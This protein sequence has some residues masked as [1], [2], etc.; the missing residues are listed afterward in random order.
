MK[1]IF[2][3][4]MLS[5]ST[6]AFSQEILLQQ[7]VKADTLKPTHGANLKHFFQGYIGLG[8]PI[9]TN[10]N[11]P[12]T[13]FGTSTA[14]DFGIRYKRK[15]AEHFAIGMD[16]GA[17]L[18]AYKI[19]QDNGKSVPDTVINNKEK[20]QINSL[21]SSVYTRINVGRRGNHIGN[22][23][24]LGIYGGWNCIKKHKSINDNAEGEKVKVITSQLKYI[25][26]FSC[27][28]LARLGV[29]RWS[30]TAGYRLSDLFNSSYAMPELP[31]LIVGVEIGIY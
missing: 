30:L 26:N 19:K 17:N 5:I 28:L 29:S 15:L 25:D 2:I 18:A 14:V 8:F 31:R 1:G 4:L 16:F 3:I 24:D 21:T 6:L 23:L 10:E 20:F 13:Q 27:G 12:Y 7:N 22:Y 9:N 11:A